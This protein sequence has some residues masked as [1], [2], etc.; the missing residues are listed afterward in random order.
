MTT[1]H[2]I[3]PARFLELAEWT[4]DDAELL[5]ANGRFRGAANRAYYAIFYAAHA[6]LE[7]IGVPR[8][9][10]HSGLANRFG[11]HYVRSGVAEGRFGQQISAAYRLRIA[12]DYRVGADITADRVS[13]SVE[14]ARAFITE[15]RRVTELSD[16]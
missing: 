5:L 13:E 14:N 16:G 8:P 1:E 2:T 15:A 4:L 3:E 11:Y 10:T 9:G 7:Q 12:S 6:A